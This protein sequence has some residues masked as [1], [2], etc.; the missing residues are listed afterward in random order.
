VTASPHDTQPASALLEGYWQAGWATTPLRPNSK[1]AF[2]PDWATREI[3]SR[4]EWNQVATPV[5][6]CGLLTGAP[7]GLVALDVDG[8]EGWTAACERLGCEEGQLYTAL[9]DT[10]PVGISAAGNMYAR[11]RLQAFWRLP[12]A[13]WALRRVDLAKAP[14]D[15]REEAVLQLRGA[16]CQ[17]AVQ[18]SVHPTAGAY[19]WVATPDL[20]YAAELPDCFR[21]PDVARSCEQRAARHAQ[22]RQE[23][24]ASIN[25]FPR[26]T[27]DPMLD[28]SAEYYVDALTD[29]VVAH[30]RA[31]CPLHTPIEGENPSLRLSGALWAC[32]SSGCA[33]N[34]GSDGGTIIDFAARLWGIEPR[35]SDY[36]KIRKQLAVKL[37]A[38]AREV[39]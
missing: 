7:S 28:V 13:H 37:G 29:T 16:G 25:P 3:R 18:P 26:V 24:R 8:A 36:W 10:N 32:H 34:P 31:V 1:A 35:G 38:W 15:G 5:D 17:S 11:R 30:G 19:R 6:G 14:R 2:L 23:P 12:K 33:P 27:G 9:L 4:S 22:A 20:R 39:S 21:G